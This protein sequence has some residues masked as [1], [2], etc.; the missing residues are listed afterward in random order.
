M[1]F[2]VGDWC[3]RRR[4]RLIVV[5]CK[6]SAAW[7]MTLPQGVSLGSVVVEID[8]IEGIDFLWR[9]RIPKGRHI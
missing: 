5:P 7:R 8:A 6:R 2:A 1:G 4:R 3:H 9:G